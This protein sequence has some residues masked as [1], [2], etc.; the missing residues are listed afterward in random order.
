MQQRR[1]ESR[2]RHFRQRVIGGI[3]RDLP[4]V[5]AHLLIL[6]DMDLGIDNRHGFYSVYSAALAVVFSM[7][8]GITSRANRRRLRRPRSPPPEPPPLISTYQTPESSRSL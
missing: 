8:A 4:M 7:N 6:P 3:G 5:S 2:A 1:I